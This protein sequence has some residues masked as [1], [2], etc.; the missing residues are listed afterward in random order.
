MKRIVWLSYLPLLSIALLSAPLATQAAELEE[1]SKS[2]QQF[3][4]L[5]PAE[6]DVADPETAE[7]DR[8]QLLSLNS[9]LLNASATAALEDNPQ[10]SQ[11]L[12]E[13]V[14]VGSKVAESGTSK[15]SA[16]ALKV[17]VSKSAVSEEADRKS[18]QSLL[19]ET[20]I[21]SA[22]AIENQTDAKLHRSLQS[23]QENGASQTSIGQETFQLSA[24]Q[25]DGNRS[26]SPVPTAPATLTSLPNA[27]RSASDLF[28]PNHH[29]LSPTAPAFSSPPTPQT[30]A[31]NGTETEF[32]VLPRA[33][34]GYNGAG[35]EG[36]DSFGHI[37]GFV[38]LR[39]NPGGDV[40]FL[41]GRV[42]LDNDANLGSNAIFGHRAYSKKDNRIYGGYIGYDTRDTGQKFFQQLGLGFESLGEIWDIRTNF[43]V[44][45][46]DTRQQVDI[47]DTNLPATPNRFEGH[48][49]I[50]DATRIQRSEVGV[51]SFDLE[52]GGRIAKIGK[53]GEARLYG[54]PYYYSAPGG[55]NTL[56]WR[57]RAEVK[58]NDYLNFGVGFQTDG[59]FGT[60][61]LFRVGA[62]F[63]SPRAKQKLDPD[64]SVL[65]RMNEFVERN[66]SIVVDTQTRQVQE[67]RLARNPET[68]LPWFFNHV[69]LGGANGDGTFENPFG[70]V[71]NA[72]NNTRSDGNDIVYVAQGSNPGIPAFTIPD[73][74]QVL[75]RGPA[76]VIPVTTIGNPTIS[77]VQLPFSNSGNFPTVTDTVTMGNDSVL[78][79]FTISP[80]SGSVGV[81]GINISNVEIR[82]NRVST[83]GTDAGGI[84]LN[85]ISG[86]ATI[87]NNQVQT[88]GSTS[89]SIPN[90][91]T[92]AEEFPNNGPHGIEISLFSGTLTTATISG[93]TV[94]TQGDVAAGVFV[95]A[96]AASTVGNAII[97]NNTVM[98]QGRGSV[99][100]SISPD[101]GT[102]N[103][104]TISGNTVTTQGQAAPGIT[105]AARDG[106]KL[107]A[108]TISGNTV[109][110][111]GRGANAI[112]LTPVF[113]NTTVNNATISGNTLVTRNRDGNGIFL[114]AREATVNNTTIADNNITLSGRDAN[115]IELDATLSTSTINNTT[116]SGN[117]IVTNGAERL[118]GIY[119]NAYRGTISNTT[120][121]GN[122]ISTNSTNSGKGIDATA[123]LQGTI[124]TL[125]ISGNTINT[126]GVDGDGVSLSA[127][128]GSVIRNATISGNTITTRKDGGDGISIRARQAGVTAAISN[129][130]IVTLDNTIGMAN[131]VFASIPMGTLGIP[132]TT[133]CLSLSGNTATTTAAT[134]NPFH[135]STPGGLGLN[136]QI[137]DTA[138]TF[139]TIQA[140]NT[141]N[142]NGGAVA[143]RF[144][145]AVP[146]PSF[147][148]VTACP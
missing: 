56:G 9:E 66:P 70:T 60:N 67:E 54:G 46:G 6:L 112:A 88:A 13:S 98:T 64:S 73:K 65:A 32:R 84:R 106:G 40:T 82:D 63:P 16:A 24:E 90:I 125:T 100:I 22:P 122:N 85:E 109:D 33:G 132:P 36:S 133:I 20:E 131:G 4:E 120:V 12:L 93:N 59:L 48:F 23:S 71:Q 62:S 72:L 92:G 38:P 113:N 43:Y 8:S 5:E 119:F 123:G 143:F 128:T 137:V 142:A 91:I 11:P 115:A 116:I 3:P 99:G 31:A 68:G 96:D 1:N 78:S 19:F 61:L 77:S 14:P 94:S 101:E 103:G 148:N 83:T 95:L 80:P 124:D 138:N 140:N 74:V 35:F 107:G 86:F 52:G 110:T 141:A 145:P 45:I 18:N 58:P 55:T 44:P 50:V 39:Q 75:S 2:S 111:S 136:F 10:Q 105:V 17:A 53:T 27:S 89:R 37:E 130:T 135:F 30:Q 79:G 104:S 69:T 81:F 97:S 21:L 134:S 41:E 42:L 51:F 139:P 121:S 87:T 127:R 102:F 129:N 57:M 118:S 117:T 26:I 29:T 49:L 25:S 34:V 47:V 114:A 76:Q 146:N 108:V 144:M 147:A 28:Q 15:S 7:Q 126:Y